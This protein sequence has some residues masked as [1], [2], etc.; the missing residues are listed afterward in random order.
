MSH[1]L[2]RTLIRR[3]IVMFVCVPIILATW[4]IPAYVNKW[5]VA[6]TA[7]GSAVCIMVWL[8]VCIVS[9]LFLKYPP[10]ERKRGFIFYWFCTAA[11]FN[12]VWQIPLILFRS[13]ITQAEPT[14]TNLLKFIA[15][16]GYG[17]ADSHYGRVSEWMMSEETWW[18]LAIVISVVGLVLVWRGRDMRGFLLLGIAGALQSYNASLYMVYDAVTGFNNIAP[19]ST[20]SLVLYWGFNPLWALTALVASIYS[21]RF[22]LQKAE[23][24]HT[25]SGI[26]S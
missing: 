8:A 22:V 17:L 25:A 15:W 13:S 18:F 6:N 3:G 19:H 23:A 16:W 7:R 5:D 4:A 24:G 2:T 26:Q 21:F 10:E 14:R 1:A 12:V 11:L 20:I 9:T